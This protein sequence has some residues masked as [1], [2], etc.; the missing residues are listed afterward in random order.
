LTDN[1]SKVKIHVVDPL[2]VGCEF[3]TNVWISSKA[4]KELRKFVTKGPGKAFLGKLDHYARAGFGRFEFQGGPIRH[5]WSGVWRVAHSA[6][7]FRLIG[8]YGGADRGEF[9]VVDAFKKKGQKLTSA[10]RDRIDIVAD[11]MRRKN[12]RKRRS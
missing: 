5:E 8:F 12:W 7:L 4:A 10:Q 11:I 9:I 1:N 3:L 6:S 2:F